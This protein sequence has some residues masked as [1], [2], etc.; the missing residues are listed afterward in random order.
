M[1]QA[2]KKCAVCSIKISSESNT[3]YC[4]VHQH[5]FNLLC[6]EFNA[7][8]RENNA[9]I[10][11]NKLWKDF[12]IRQKPNITNTESV[13]VIDVE[14]L[15]PDGYQL[16]DGEY[17]RM[18]SLLTSKEIEKIAE[19]HIVPFFNDIGFKIQKIPTT[20]TTS[21]SVD[22]EC[23]NLGIE[24]TTLHDYLPKHKD[25]D[26]LMRR[27]FETRSRICAYI[28]LKGDE[29]KIE[30]LDEKKLDNDTSILCLRQHIS[31]YRP[32]LTTK[33]INKYLQDESESHD[34]QIIVIDSRLAPFDSLS[35][36]WEVKSILNNLG[37]DL[38]SLGGVLIAS[39]KEI[40]SDMLEE[41][42]FVFANNANCQ[43]DHEILRR[44]SNFSL[45]TTS[46]WKTVNQTFVTFSGRTSIISPC[47]DCPE[48]EELNARGLPTFLMNST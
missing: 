15:I 16:I 10:N 48:K 43:K 26:K 36:K 44:L 33:I 38:R 1:I 34:M 4:D 9:N 7:L 46:E 32:K 35:L 19:I 47:L 17:V 31:C 2:S 29:P 3:K 21:R 11:P 41:P 24:V 18:T 30:I 45:A 14:M 8:I 20:P 23:G 39:P 28:Y 25:V 42:I 13:R 27:H 40:D 12:L 5:Y 6:N 22:Y 37:V